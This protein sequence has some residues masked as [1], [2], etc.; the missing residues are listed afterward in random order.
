MK[1]LI[2]CEVLTFPPKMQ[3]ELSLELASLGCFQLQLVS[4]HHY[5]NLTPGFI[6]FHPD[7]WQITYTINKI[8][9]LS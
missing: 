7:A 9:F 8:C 2:F 5:E 6:W 4:I 3:M 1:R